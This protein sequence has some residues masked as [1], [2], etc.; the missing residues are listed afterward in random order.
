MWSEETPK[1]KAMIWKRSLSF[2]LYL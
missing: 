2:Q 1:E